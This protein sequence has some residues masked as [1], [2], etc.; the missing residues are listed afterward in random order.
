MPNETVTNVSLTDVTD[1]LLGRNNDT[2]T[3]SYYVLAVPPWR[4][5]C[6]YEVKQPITFSISPYIDEKNTSVKTTV[7]LNSFVVVWDNYRLNTKGLISGA[8]SYN[9]TFTCSV[10]Y[11]IY[12]KDN[13]GKFAYT[14]DLSLVYEDEYYKTTFGFSS[15]SIT[16]NGE[17]VSASVPSGFDINNVSDI[18]LVVKSA[19]FKIKTNVIGW[20]SFSESFTYLRPFGWSEIGVNT[21]QP[22]LRRAEVGNETISVNSSAE[23]LKLYCNG[24]I[25]E[26]IS[27]NM[28]TMGPSTSS[29][30]Q[31]LLNS[32]DIQVNNVPYNI[33]ENQ[34]YLKD[35]S[36]YTSSITNVNYRL[37]VWKNIDGAYCEFIRRNFGE[38]GADLDAV[39]SAAVSMDPPVKQQDVAN[40][41]EN[42][43]EE[44]DS[45]IENSDAI[46][47]DSDSTDSE[48]SEDDSSSDSNSE[49]KKKPDEIV[50]PDTASPTDAE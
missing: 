49:D 6:S 37:N 16:L 7:P 50:P 26:C 36:S 45:I 24:I 34:N 29:P 27:E 10:D 47:P 48:T 12:L 21:E 28:L 43:D 3:Q 14:R 39:I 1:Y 4:G 44:N 2:Y 41:F 22:M 33:L 23:E 11:C 31:L 17:D 32:Y 9:D 35:T 30:F 42:S 8:L 15:N 46:E 5:M 20:K 13:T 40:T 18:Y 25:T 19:N 38:T